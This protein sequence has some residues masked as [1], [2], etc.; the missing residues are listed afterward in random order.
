MPQARQQET[1]QIFEAAGLA[2]DAAKLREASYLSDVAGFDY[3]RFGLSPADASLLDPA[4]RVFLETALAALDDAGYGGAAL[5]NENVGVFVGASPM[6]LFQNAVTLA[7]PEQAEQIYMLNV[8]SNVVARLSYLKNWSGPAASVDTACSS[9]LTALHQACRS[10]RDGECSVAVVGGAHLIDL[11][12]KTD[13][14]FAIE[15]ASGLTKTFDAGADG[16][17]AGEGAAVF[18]LKP[19]HAAKRDN[20]AIHGADPGGA[21]AFPLRHARCAAFTQWPRTRGKPG[22]FAAV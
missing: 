20:D 5:Q 7:F 18:V 19:L 8:P 15:S 17:G 6:R 21:A 16:V 1:R 3:K 4:Q 11:P 22:G 2:F 10:L 14:A 9:V 12:V 13:A